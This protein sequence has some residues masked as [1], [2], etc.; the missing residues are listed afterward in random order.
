VF[1]I[2]EANP[3]DGLTFKMPTLAGSTF[4]II[5]PEA[6]DGPRFVSETV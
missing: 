5:V 1:P 2:I 4:E 6:A 3:C